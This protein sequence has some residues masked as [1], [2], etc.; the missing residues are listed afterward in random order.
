MTE[1]NN[2]DF[3]TFDDVD[4]D[5]ADL[6]EQTND[7]GDVADNDAEPD[8]SEDNGDVAYDNA[9][10]DESADAD[11][12]ETEKPYADEGA[13]G[14][15]ISAEE[16]STRINDELYAEADERSNV[17]D[18]VEDLFNESAE[19]VVGDE[20]ENADRD[21]DLQDDALDDI[22]PDRGIA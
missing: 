21:R 10:D 14:E 13:V 16:Q 22:E 1:N 11:I 7:V 4:R 20:G 5:E 12:G 2:D 15:D 8:E 6:N 18:T 19:S 17:E 9:Y 3:D